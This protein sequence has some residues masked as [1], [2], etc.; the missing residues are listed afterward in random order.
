AQVCSI[1]HA[2]RRLSK[3]TVELERG[4]LKPMNLSRAPEHCVLQVH[5]GPLCIKR[6]AHVR[7]ALVQS[8][9][10]EATDA[11]GWAARPRPGPLRSGHVLSLARSAVLVATVVVEILLAFVRARTSNPLNATPGL[12]VNFGPRL[13]TGRIEIL[14]P[15]EQW[16]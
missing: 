4:Q 3:G 12:D 5:V 7:I 9:D 1:G 15:A 10:L 6:L 2:R 14:T 8:P 16:P 13:R 11:I